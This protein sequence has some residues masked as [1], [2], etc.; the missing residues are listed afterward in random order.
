[1]ADAALPDPYEVFAVKYAE[2]DGVRGEH[3]IDPDPHARDPMPMDYFVW[4]AR[5]GGR[6]YVIDTGFTAD[7]AARRGRTLLRTAAQGLESIGIDAATVADVIITHLHYDHVGG[8]AQFPAARF[9]IQDREVAFATGRH[10]TH[11]SLNAA[12]NP[13]HVADFVEVVHAGR[14][15]F[16]DGS[17]VLASGLSL[18]HVGGHT[19]GLQVVR[20]WTRRGWLVLASD[21]SHYYENMRDGRPFPIVFDVGA[22]LDGF[23]RMRELS[24][25]DELIVPGHDPLVLDTFPPASD[26]LAGIAVRLD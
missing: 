20:I 13:Q 25:C 5:G 2:R 14:A 15:V 11:R 10:M 3:F 26:E 22:V 17:A 8:I 18:H 24:G 16:H 23:R 19:D 6:T 21:A 7:D 4:A 9:H 12:F 1:M